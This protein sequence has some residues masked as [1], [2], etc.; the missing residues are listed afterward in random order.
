MNQVFKKQLYWDLFE[1]CNSICIKCLSAQYNIETETDG[2]RNTQEVSYVTRG[3]SLDQTLRSA[4][5]FCKIQIVKR[6]LGHVVS[7]KTT[8]LCHRSETAATANTWMDEWMTM[9][10]PLKCDWWALKFEPH[11]I[12]RFYKILL[13]FLSSII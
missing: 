8:Q 10:Y 12:F 11:R 2:N 7:V 9:L 13:M 1:V 4:S 5:V 6:S 3:K